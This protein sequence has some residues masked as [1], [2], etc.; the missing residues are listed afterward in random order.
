MND[1]SEYRT[2]PDEL[3]ID[4]DY[5]EFLSTFSHCFLNVVNVIT[6]THK[7]SVTLSQQANSVPGGIGRLNGRS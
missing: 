3:K 2:V 4:V 1:T 5:L 7:K 6:K